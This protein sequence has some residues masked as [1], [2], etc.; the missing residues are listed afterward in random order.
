MLL[1][2]GPDD[3]ITWSRGALRNGTLKATVTKVRLVHASVRHLHEKS[4]ER[5]YAKWGEPVS[6][7]YTAGAICDSSVQI[8]EALKNLGV[9]VSDEDRHGFMCAWHYVNH[10]LG[11]PEQWVMP[12]DAELVDRI[13]RVE[14]EKEWR[15]SDD[16][17]F[18]TAQALKFYKQEMVPPP[19]YDPFVAMVRAAFGD[20]YTDMAGIPRN[21]ALD[22]GAKIA[23]TGH[24]VASNT[25]GG[26][27]GGTA[28]KATGT[29]PYDAILG[30]AS[31]AFNKVEEYA[32]KHDKD[33][34]PQMHQELH[35]NR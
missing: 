29:N 1:D 23:A 9:H 15:E 25:F 8:L 27:F 7:K 32:L 20:K 10:Y 4:A 14:R 16:G 34:Q 26:L 33:D 28:Q 17:K 11:T 5:D 6:Q 35:D 19:V 31:K 18:M 13:W 30:Q 22:T 3:L 24:S 2:D 12:K 21:A